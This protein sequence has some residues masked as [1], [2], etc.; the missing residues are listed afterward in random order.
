[1]ADEKLNNFNNNKDPEGNRSRHGGCPHRSKPPRIKTH[2]RLL[3]PQDL[4]EGDE[5]EDDGDKDVPHKVI[6]PA[7]RMP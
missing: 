2:C 1:M 3:F 7:R 6:S 5:G 4:D